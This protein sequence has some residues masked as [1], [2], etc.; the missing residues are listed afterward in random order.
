MASRSFNRKQSLEK[1]VKSLYLTVAIGSSGAPTLSV[2]HGIA[3]ISRTSTGLYRITLSDK[4]SSLK[5][6]EVI[7][8]ATSAQDLNYQLKAEDVASG[9]TIDFFCLAGA[10]ETDPASG[11]TLHIQV[12]LKNTS[13]V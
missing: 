1:E 12:D 6:F 7:H 11:S 13:V 2:G 9:K 5:S 10:T 8:K 4:Y 3:S